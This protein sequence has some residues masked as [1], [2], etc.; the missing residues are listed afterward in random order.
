MLHAAFLRSQVA[1]ARIKTYRCI[2]G[3]EARRASSRSIRPTISAPIGRR[4]R[5]WCR[6]RQFRESSSITRTH[7]PLAKDKIRCV[8]EPIAIVVAESRYIAEDALDDIAVELEMLSAVVDIEKALDKIIGAG[9][10]RS[11]QSTSRPMCAR[12]RA[13]IQGRH[14]GASDPQAPLSLRARHLLADRE[15]AAWSR[16]GMRAPNT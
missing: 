12:P 11:R 15:L 1:H 13:T 5:C 7:V 3:A 9:P 6:H 4:G 8:G 16:N 14:E 10:R 2:G